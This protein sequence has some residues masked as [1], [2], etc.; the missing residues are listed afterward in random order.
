MYLH[1]IVSIVSVFMLATPN[2]WV[3]EPIK[4]SNKGLKALLY[5]TSRPWWLLIIIFLFSAGSS[6]AFAETNSVPADTQISVADLSK[7]AEKVYLSTQAK[8]LSAPTNAEAAW[9]FGRA[10]FDWAEYA[11][12]DKQR[13][14]IAQQGIAA[15]RQLIERQPESAPGHYYL[16]MNLGQLARTKKLGALRIVDQM[17]A[18]FK[19]ALSLDP[20]LDYGGPDRNLGLLYRDAPGW[21]ASIGSK[22]KAKVHLQNALKQA[23]DSPENLLNLIEADLQWGDKNAAIRSLRTLD[24]DWPVALKNYSGDEWASSWVDWKK[25]REDSRKKALGT[26]SSLRPP[27]ETQ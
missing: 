22:S 6:P 19:I 7:R 13:A 1:L 14:G 16:A 10:T 11:T 17:E 24:E 3:W 2:S 9:Q 27:R 18:E 26:S 8:F 4:R 21:P 20:K 12:S 25:R 15:C 23:P 5:N